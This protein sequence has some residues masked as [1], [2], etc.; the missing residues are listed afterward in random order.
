MLGLFGKF[1]QNC[2]ILMIPQK[3]YAYVCYKSVVESEEAYKHMN[4][5][6]LPSCQNRPNE[7]VLYTFY[8]NEGEMILYTLNFCV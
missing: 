5:Y 3:S 4:G 1:G 6:K 7:V 2:D 8:V